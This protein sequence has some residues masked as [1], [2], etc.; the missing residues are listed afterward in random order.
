MMK[1]DQLLKTL[2]TADDLL[3]QQVLQ[4]ATLTQLV[5]ELDAIFAENRQELD[6]NQKFRHNFTEIVN[7]VYLLTLEK[8]PEQ[9]DKMLFNPHLIANL[10]QPKS[11]VAR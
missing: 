7:Y 6:I 5:V 8:K 11:A 4:D 9:R 1:R 10:L 3:P 2:R